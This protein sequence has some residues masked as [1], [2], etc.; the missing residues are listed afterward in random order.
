MCHFKQFS[1]KPNGDPSS[2][3][4]AEQQISDQGGY[5]GRTI[6]KYGHRDH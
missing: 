3:S 1:S 6:Y 4:Y 2:F 5:A